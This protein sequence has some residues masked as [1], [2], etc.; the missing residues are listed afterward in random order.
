M[1]AKT[2]TSTIIKHDHIRGTKEKRQGQFS[3]NHRFNNIEDDAMGLHTLVGILKLKY[4][5]VGRVGNSTE[6]Q[7]KRV[8]CEAVLSITLMSFAMMTSHWCKLHI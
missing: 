6:E 1:A 7:A 5:R 8:F 3:P 4:I 2:T